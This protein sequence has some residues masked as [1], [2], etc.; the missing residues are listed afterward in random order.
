MVKTFSLFTEG[1][2]YEHDGH[3]ARIAIPIRSSIEKEI[4]VL[5]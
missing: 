2:P 5:Y 3:P 4:S 1:A